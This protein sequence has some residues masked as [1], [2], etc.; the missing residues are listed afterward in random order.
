MRAYGIFSDAVRRRV[1]R[2]GQRLD[3]DLLWLEQADRALDFRSRSWTA[4]HDSFDH[5][6]AE[7]APGAVVAQQHAGR[8]EHGLV[9]GDH[10][11]RR[12]YAPELDQ[13]DRDVP[14]VRLVHHGGNTIGIEPG[15][16]LQ[17]RLCMHGDRRS[18]DRLALTFTAPDRPDSLARA[19]TVGNVSAAIGLGRDR[20]VRDQVP[21]M[22]FRKPC[23]AL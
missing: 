20:L 23:E 22:R 12:R 2:L 6:V 16:A 9:G 8:A 13:V 19:S 1:D 5:L 4:A 17:F 11:G 14:A 15:D 3:L 7:V 18:A 21:L 10:V